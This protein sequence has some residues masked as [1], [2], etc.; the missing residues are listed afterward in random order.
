MIE[1]W[2]NAKHWKTRL[3]F[4]ERAGSPNAIS[5]NIIFTELP[6]ASSKASGNIHISLFYPAKAKH[7][8]RSVIYNSQWGP[9]HFS[10]LACVADKTAE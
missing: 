6:C 7:G 2:T 3:Y 10:V 9:S 5:Q 1:G 4:K 8:L